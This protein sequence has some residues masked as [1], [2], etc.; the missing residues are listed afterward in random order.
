M[1]KNMSRVRPEALSDTELERAAYMI[2]DES[3]G[4]GLPISYQQALLERFGKTLGDM[5]DLQAELNEA[6]DAADA[7]RYSLDSL[8]NNI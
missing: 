5:E 2:L 1:E 7:L 8:E 4:M 3:T 6:L